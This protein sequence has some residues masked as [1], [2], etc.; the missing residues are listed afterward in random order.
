[1]TCDDGLLNTLTDMLAVLQAESVPCL[2]FVTAASC[3]D[4]PG[5]L[6][7]EELYHCMRGKSLNGLASQLPPEPGS[8]PP[9]AETFQSQ[10][11]NLVRRASQ[12]DAKTRA[13]WMAQVRANSEPTHNTASDAGP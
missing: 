7:D 10:W 9:P 5:M 2:F 3:S 12:L 11:W 8:D 6:W 4:D 1:V 13:D